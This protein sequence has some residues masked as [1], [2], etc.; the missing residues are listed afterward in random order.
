MRRFSDHTLTARITIAISLLAALGLALFSGFALLAARKVDGEALLREKLLVRHALSSIVADVPR[1]QESFS[2]W[3]EAVIRA[4][5][6]DERWIAENFGG[7]MYRFFGHDRTYILDTR[8]N[9]I[10]AAS[11]GD[12][13]SPPHFAEDEKPAREIVT[14]LRNRMADRF[15]ADGKV[16]TP[17]SA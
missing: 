17:R 13:V 15:D 9:L 3:D 7:W 5:A 12:V 11:R 14:R 10:F 2:T 4:A 16:R 1:E 6:R 8:D